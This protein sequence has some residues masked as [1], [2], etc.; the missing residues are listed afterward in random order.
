MSNEEVEYPERLSHGLALVK[1]FLAY[2]AL[3]TDKY[4]SFRFWD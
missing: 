2:V 3:M 4:T 1:R